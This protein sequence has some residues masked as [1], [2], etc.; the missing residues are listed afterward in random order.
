[1]FAQGATGGERIDGMHYAGLDVHK[2][3]ISFCIR[4]ADGQVV[5]EGV[6]AA[7]R[8][9]VSEWIKSA[10][11]RC[12]AGMEATMFTGCSITLSLQA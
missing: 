2:K 3:T 8:A 6:I 9:A 12:I 1:M 5:N 4:R 11:S 10:S 7:H